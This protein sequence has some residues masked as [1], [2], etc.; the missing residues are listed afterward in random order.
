MSVTRH[1]LLA[2]GIAG[3]LA[4]SGGGT[5]ETIGDARQDLADEAGSPSDAPSVPD[6]E[7]LPDAPAGPDAEGLPDAPS[8]PDAEGLPDAPSVPDAEGLPDAPSVPDAEGPDT[9]MDTGCD[10]CPPVCDPPDTVLV[11]GVCVPS[12]GVGGGDTCVEA[13]SNL[14]DGLPLLLSHDCELCCDRSVY[15]A[16]EKHAYHIIHIEDVWAWDAILEI[17]QA[18][19]NPGPMINS[20][21]PTPAV[22]H[23]RWAQKINATWYAS[24][25]EMADVI[26]AALV[27]VDTAPQIVMIDEL[28]GNTISLITGCANRMREVYPQWAGR[29][30]AYLVN[31]PNI[32][33]D[34][35]NPA[36][37]ALL[38][39]DAAISVEMYPYQSSYCKAGS[40]TASRDQWLTDFFRGNQGSFPQKRFHWLMERRTAL[41]SNSHVT[42]IFGVIDAY[43]DK[44]A[45]AIFLDRLFYI[46]RNKSGYGSV[47]LVENG[48]VGAYKWDQPSMS[49]TSRDLAFQ[50][51][52]DHY[53]VLGE[54]SSLKGPVNCN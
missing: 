46:W 54:T 18:H 33:Y 20:Q 25:E 21:N 13:G 11:D 7:G 22:P 45:P 31:G 16:P 35:L 24:G 48:G 50:Q 15:P 41:D 37:D 19:P 4:C 30:G 17:T 49:N 8:V 26:H 43:M 6:A 3:L 32:A 10:D 5:P 40:S 2:V 27:P 51:S 39:A 9:G 28:N 1:L 47:I 42:V 36:V 34:K 44:A 38:Q 52:F 23:D 14:C 12:C 53:C 29:W